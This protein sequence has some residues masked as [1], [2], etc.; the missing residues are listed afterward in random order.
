VWLPRDLN[1]LFARDRQ[2][3]AGCKQAEQADALIDQVLMD[4]NLDAR[5]SENLLP[6]DRHRECRE[7]HV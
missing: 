7:E 2:H 1:E 5:P 3:I 4:R 6:A